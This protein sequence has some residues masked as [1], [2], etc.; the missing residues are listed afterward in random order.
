M[1][2]F[3]G[4]AILALMVALIIGYTFF[5]AKQ[6]EKQEA[7]KA[8]SE[9]LFQFKSDDIVEIKLVKPTDQVVLKRE[10]TQWGIIEPLVDQ[11]DNQNVQDFLAAMANEKGSE[12]VPEGGA[13]QWQNYHL[14]TPG[15]SV[16][17]VKSDKS[18]VAFSVGQFAAFDGNYFLRL[19]D[20]LY[21]GSPEW[22]RHS[23]KTAA[24][25]RNKKILR[26][27]GNVTELT[28]TTNHPEG[29]DQVVLLK[30][31]DKWAFGG[32]YKGLKLDES[33]VESYIEQV[34]SLQAQDF[35][36][37]T[38]DSK[39]IKDIGLDKPVTKLVMKFAPQEP[40]LANW[41]LELGPDRDAGQY[42]RSSSVE[43]AFK[44]TTYDGEKFRRLKNYFRDGK[45]P[46]RLAVADV[47]RIDSQTVK[48]K[49]EV[50]KE[51]M[52][53]KL[54]T[55]KDGET[56][57]DKNLESM[58]TKLS[59]LEV[60]EFLGADKGKGLKPA[61]NQLIFR[62]KEGRVLLDLAWGEEFKPS[63]GPQKDLQ[64]TYAKTNLENEVLGLQSSDLKDLSVENLVK[65]TPKNES[66]KQESQK[67]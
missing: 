19:G 1:K 65:V 54:K 40:A 23:Q 56:L 38:V 7:A 15:L 10:G 25:L 30:Q 14:A 29:S 61:K 16:E 52:E 13:I 6:S 18:K 26:Q 45:S 8:E 2:S 5:D 24:Q 55:A 34:K 57:D 35:L 49:I 47:A 58:L 4:T 39:K 31:G 3:K 43:G 28:I 50:L 48:G 22:G 44:I 33:K 20:Q 12:I 32:K 59:N 60:K 46:L 42:G 63:K 66:L 11:A 9:K 67:Q 62:D 53:W 21:L 27:S 37:G 51:G 64:L 36:S 17:L 41:Q